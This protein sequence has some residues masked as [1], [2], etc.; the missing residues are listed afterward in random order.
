MSDRELARRIRGEL[1][2]EAFCTNPMRLLIA[3]PL[4]AAILGLSTCLAM[5]PLPVFAAMPVLLLLGNLY[6]SLFFF[7][8][9]VGHGAVS[10]VRAVQTLVTY[11]SFAIFFL[12]ASVWITS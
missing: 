8:H 6:V 11:F 9:E 2:P 1:P 12:A 5:F 3:A 7:G 4:L 10:R